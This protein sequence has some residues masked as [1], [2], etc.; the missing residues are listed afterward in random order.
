MIKTAEWVIDL[1]PEGGSKG[2]EIIACGTPE[3]LTSIERSYTGRF[4]QALL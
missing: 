1:G 3:M 4:L 2:G